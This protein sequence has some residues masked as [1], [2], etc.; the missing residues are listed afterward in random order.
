MA[1]DP[2]TESSL[3]VPRNY[4]RAC[5]LLLLTEEAGY[6]YELSSHLPGLGADTGTLQRGAT[7]R[8]LRQLEH[9]GLVLSHWDHSE[10]GPPRRVYTITSDGLEWL[11]QAAVSV[12]ELRRGM[13]RFLRLYRQLTQE[14]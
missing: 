13:T 12:E 10:A 9:E 11:H 1:P 6:G 2:F 4:L 5:I 3:E 7:Y 14:P 8:V